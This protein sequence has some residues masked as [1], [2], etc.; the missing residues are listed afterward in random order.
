MYPLQV[1]RKMNARASDRQA[2][3]AAILAAF[4]LHYR[5]FRRFRVVEPDRASKQYDLALA[6]Y[7]ENPGFQHRMRE[8]APGFRLMKPCTGDHVVPPHGCL[9]VKPISRY[10]RGDLAGMADGS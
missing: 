2:A 7:E 4:T 9:V 10:G 6:T 5:L 8:I 1:I 3:E